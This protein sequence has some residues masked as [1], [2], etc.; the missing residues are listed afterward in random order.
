[1]I[2]FII[3]TIN[4]KVCHIL[5]S[6][7]KELLLREK[8]SCWGFWDFGFGHISPF[9]ESTHGPGL[10]IYIIY[11]FFIIS[12]KGINKRSSAYFW[13]FGFFFIRSF[14][15]FVETIWVGQRKNNGYLLNFIPLI[16]L[17][18]TTLRKNQEKDFQA[19]VKW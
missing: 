2:I 13:F 15:I 19:K 12:L 17:K 4:I 18:F 1:M 5:T 14:Y 16:K 10:R 6:N 3:E 9:V 11:V 8:N 7:L